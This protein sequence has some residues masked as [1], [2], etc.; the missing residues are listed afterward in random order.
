MITT[1]SG[2]GPAPA[3]TDPGNREAVAV[4]VF[5]APR[6]LVWRAMTTPEHVMQWYGPRDTRLSSCEIDLRPG[7]R[8]RFV[9]AGP[10]GSEVGFSGVYREVDPPRR[11]VN[12]WTFEPMPGHEAIETAEFE[13]HDGRTTVRLSIAFPS[14]ED[15]AGWAGSGAFGGWAESLDRLS[16]VIAGLS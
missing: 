5:D 4:R 16:E 14:V 15:Y 9:M 6:D 2:S 3:S 13:E 8:F 11:I 7:G 10:D 1:L 12:T